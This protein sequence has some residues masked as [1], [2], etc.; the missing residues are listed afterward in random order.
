M[1]DRTEKVAILLHTLGADTVDAAL[2]ALKGKKADEVRNRVKAI[3]ESPPS[4]SVVEEVLEEF[5][6]FFTFAVKAANAESYW[7]E[8]TENNGLRIADTD[9]DSADDRLEDSIV[10]VEPEPAKK[11]EIRTPTYIEDDEEDEDDAD[12]PSFRIFEPTEN[13]MRDLRKLH[14]AQIAGALKGERPKTIAIVL[15]CLSKRKNASVIERLPE[16][17]HGELLALM[18]SEIKIPSSLLKKIIRTVVRKALTVEKPEE[19]AENPLLAIAGVLRELPRE[20]RNNMMSHLRE[21]NE[22]EAD[23][24]QKMLYLFEDIGNYG[25]R[26]IQ[27]ILAE[28]D[29]GQLVIALHSATSVLRDRVLGNLSKRAKESLIEELELLGKQPEEVVKEAQDSIAEVIANLDQADELEI[30]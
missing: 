30:D 12:G 29:K 27:K 15:K 8:F 2:G 14:A 10:E 13:E 28:V 9:D 7:D 3:E 25:D 19:E 1:L 6:T 17:I 16:E 11:E 5:A 21:K 26:S 4:V 23:E 20:V 18:L 24:L 22:E